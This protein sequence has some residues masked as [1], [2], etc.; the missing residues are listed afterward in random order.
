MKRATIFLLTGLAASACCVQAFALSTATANVSVGFQQSG[1]VQII[2]P[3]I[4]PTVTA[5]AISPTA[6]FAGSV[7]SAGANG[8]SANSTQGGAGLSNATLTIRGQ[9]GDTVSTAVPES[10]QVTRTGGTEALTVKTSTNQY[11]LSNDGVVLGAGVNGNTL[12]VNVGG[13][14]SLASAGELVPGP[15]E[16]LLVVVVQYN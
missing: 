10:F 9:A 8:M 5:S 4:L 11:G 6:Q 7:P 16:G 13:S 1:G 2:T 15:Y 14:I 3:L 12:S